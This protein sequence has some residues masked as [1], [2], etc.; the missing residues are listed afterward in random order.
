MDVKEVLI[1]VE[2]NNKVRVLYM[3]IEEG[4]NYMWI[5]LVLQLYEKVII[6]VDEDVCV[7]FKVVIY[8]YYKDIEKKNYNIDKLIENLYKK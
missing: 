3:G 1:M 8:K 7:E 4:I 2:G 6:V 5:I